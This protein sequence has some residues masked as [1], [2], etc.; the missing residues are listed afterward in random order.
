MVGNL[1]QADRAG[2]GL[3]KADIALRRE[4][5]AA[6]ARASTVS[7]VLRQDLDGD[8]K[9]TRR[10]IERATWAAQGPAVEDKAGLA[11]QVDRGLRQFDANGDGTI[12]IAEAVA[13][14][15]DSPYRDNLDGLLA[16]DP[17]GD[18]RLTPKELRRLA[19]QTFARID[20]DGDETISL[21]EYQPI[22]ERVREA[23]LMRQMPACPLPSARMTKAER[24]SAPLPRGFDATVWREAARFW[25]GGLVA[26][27]PRH[28]VAKARVEPYEVLPSQMGL[29][30][31]VGTGAVQHLSGD[32]FR[33]VRP[34][35][36]MPP[37]M[38]DAHSV[39]L[40]VARGV[41][42]PPGD[43]GHSCVVREDGGTAMGVR[44]RLPE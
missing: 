31:L 33:I 25:P 26:V 40:I 23:Q 8:L 19:A 14:R 9:V 35:A 11:E 12:T 22:A 29:A 17:D 5:A 4:I 38:G 1:R 37:S 42:V 32:R 13:V 36:H 41:P 6:Q 44:C 27:D 39:T 2:D 34:I 21:E 43:P 10:E 24:D 16:L 3:D 20:R 15:L 28:V 18:G 30:Q 7:D